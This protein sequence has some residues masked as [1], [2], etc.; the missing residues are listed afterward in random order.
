[1]SESRADNR[2]RKHTACARR[3]P[4]SQIKTAGS[5]HGPVVRKQ[6]DERA[7][8][9]ALFQRRKR[10]NHSGLMMMKAAPERKRRRKDRQNGDQ[11]HTHYWTE[12]S[13]HWKHISGGRW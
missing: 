9:A 2:T 11:T 8:A 5:R 10:L 4:A 7:L 1:M 12:H 3:P 13:L 6:N